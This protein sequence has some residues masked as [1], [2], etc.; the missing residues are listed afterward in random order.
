MNVP[1]LRFREYS[2]SH[3]LCVPMLATK[4]TV[5]HHTQCINLL[6]LEQDNP[7]GRLQGAGLCFSPA[8][9]HLI[10]RIQSN[11]LII[12]CVIAGLE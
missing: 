10:Q 1:N 11:E 6:Q 4:Y 7:A 3:G 12:M 8:I 5:K 9:T 2:I